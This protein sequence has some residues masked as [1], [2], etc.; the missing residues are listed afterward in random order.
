MILID[1][2]DQVVGE[3][4]LLI[5]AHRNKRY[6]FKR[7]SVLGPGPRGR[8]HT[9]TDRWVCRNAGP[10]VQRC[11]IKKGRKGQGRVK[12]VYIDPDYKQ[13]YNSEYKRWRKQK[14]TENIERLEYFLA[15]ITE[16]I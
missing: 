11:V 1:N 14:K 10:Y 5:E 7:K 12:M 4:R 13:D 6:P 3:M 8:I 9:K 2:M 15:C 16:E